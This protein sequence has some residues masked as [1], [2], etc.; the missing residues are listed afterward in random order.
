MG[1]MYSNCF[2]CCWDWIRMCIE[3]PEPYPSTDL[4]ISSAEGNTT[5]KFGLVTRLDLDADKA[6]KKLSCSHASFAPSV[7]MEDICTTTSAFPS[8]VGTS[9]RAF[10]RLTHPHDLGEL[11]RYR[12]GT[13]ATRAA[14][15]A[16]KSYF[17]SSSTRGLHVTRLAS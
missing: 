7:A 3:L 6:S 10:F 2:I 11:G 17:E 1:F 15:T 14:F 13:L 12:P 4:L 16:E 5:R 9:S 8:W